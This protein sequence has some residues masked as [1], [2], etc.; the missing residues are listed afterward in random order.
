[1]HDGLVFMPQ[2]TVTAS[3]KSKMKKRKFFKF[4]SSV[5]VFSARK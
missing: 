3:Y 2:V 5:S 1:M 4:V